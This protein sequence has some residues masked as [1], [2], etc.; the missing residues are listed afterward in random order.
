MRNFINVSIAIL[1]TSFVFADN[2]N[3]N[4][5]IIPKNFKTETTFSGDLSD[6][7]SFHLI[8]GK[9]KKNKK[10]TVFAYFFNGTEV[11]E[12]PTLTTEKGYNILSY[13]YKDNVLSLLLTCNFKKKKSFLKKID[14]NLREN[15]FKESDV[16]KHEDFVKLIRTKD[17]SILLYK[18]DEF[19]SIKEFI[20]D[21]SVNTKILKIDK[22]SSF[23]D[24]FKDK[25]VATVRNDEF[26]RNGATNS[27]KL[28]YNNNS[29]NFTKDTDLF[30]NTEF[31]N[32]NLS[33]DSL[34]IEKK[35]FDNDF[36]GN[37][38]KMASFFAD[39]KLYQFIQT[40]EKAYINLFDTNTGLKLNSI[41]LDE[42]LNAYTKNNS[43]FQGIGDFLKHS[44][45]SHYIVTITA[46]KTVNNNIRIRLDYVD[47]DYSYYNNF[48]NFNQMMHQMNQNLMRQN[49]PAGFGPNVN[50]E[51][52]FN[53]A[54]VTKEKRF[55][56]LLIDENG[57]LLNQ[58]LPETIY[59]EIDKKKEIDHLKDISHFKYQSS[60]FLKSGFRYI[61]Y[62]KSSK[63]FI[64]NTI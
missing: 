4:E 53:N 20:G 50:D 56:E 58:N 55:F 40:K 32:L 13:H 39:D 22:L 10:Y 45:K 37:F 1:F 29:L 42:S 64:I 27:L 36:N 60:C 46:N 14:Y 51:F 3:F 47:I 23:S 63:S 30:R 52:V 16:Y 11:I 34:F 59:K 18:K 61:A 8:F 24:Y 31:I 21:E 19:L 41:I 5:I 25:Y 57:N 12:L 28:Y 62:D 26:V 17:R 15:N 7:D 48:L 9:N 2:I 49:L 43:K 54:S 38:Q 6:K 33:K 35:S 44:K